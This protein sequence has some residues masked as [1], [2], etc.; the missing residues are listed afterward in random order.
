MNLRPKLLIILML[1]TL[2]ACSVESSV[3][4]GNAEEKNTITKTVIKTENFYDETVGQ[5]KQLNSYINETKLPRWEENYYLLPTSTAA[6]SESNGF[7]LELRLE[8]RTATDQKSRGL[9]LNVMVKPYSKSSYQE[10]IDQGY[11]KQE[12]HDR[13]YLVHPDS[14]KSEIVFAAD[15]YLYNMNSSTYLTN[16]VVYM[17][18]T[19]ELMQLSFNLDQHSKYK[20]YLTVDLTNYVIPSYFTNSEKEPVSIM[21]SYSN[22]YGFQNFDLKEQELLIRNET[23]H[24]SETKGSSYIV[25]DILLDEGYGENYTEIQINGVTGYLNHSEPYELI[26]E[27]DGIQLS[28]KPGTEVNEKT[29]SVWTKEVPNWAEEAEKTFVSLFVYDDDASASEAPAPEKIKEPNADHSTLALLKIEEN[30]FVVNGISIGDTTSDV[31]DIILSP[32]YEGPDEEG[33]YEWIQR[34]EANNTL[35][36]FSRDTVESFVLEASMKEL[37]QAIEEQYQGDIYI[38]EEGIKY[39]YIPE[40]AQLLMFSA[41]VEDSTIAHISVMKADGNFHYWLENGGIK[42]ISDL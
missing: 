23:M 40:S 6:Y 5:I 39:L 16:T 37:V 4:M 18:S 15:D 27:K 19:Q 10:Y 7:S 21:V 22:S 28:I 9:P 26:A 32:T 25:N 41:N 8:L 2:A 20:E 34:Y 17:L 29:G 13:E 36:S 12:Y 11:V 14:K 3:S 24:L 35:V 30:H 1:F 38:N 31:K 33:F 42:K